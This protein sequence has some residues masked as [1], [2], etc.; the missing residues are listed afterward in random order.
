MEIYMLEQDHH[1]KCE[2]HNTN[3]ME[4]IFDDEL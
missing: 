4:K 1:R 2:R 3:V